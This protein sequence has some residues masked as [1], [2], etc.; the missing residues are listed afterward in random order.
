MPI[1]YRQLK[2]TRGTDV[3]PDGERT[4]R[5]ERGKLVETKYGSTRLVTEWSAGD[6]WWQSWN[7]FD[8][9]GLAF[10]QDLLDGLGVDRSKL[11]D[12]DQ[13][14]AELA[15][16]EG[17]KYRVKTKSNRGSQGDRWFTSTY[18]QSTVSVL[19]TGLLSGAVPKDDPDIPF[20][21]NDFVEP[22]KTGGLFDDDDIP[23]LREPDWLD[24]VDQF[25]GH[26]NR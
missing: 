23:F 13:L 7:Q 1:D 4:A 2:E 14:T 24:G 19:R 5:L 17:H 20:D 22:P 8:G 25:R 11:T 15:A 21:T 6:L 9:Q 12:D 10:T 18:I 16:A 3:P 26:A